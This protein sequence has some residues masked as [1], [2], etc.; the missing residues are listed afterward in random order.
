MK[1]RRV[2]LIAC[3]KQKRTGIHKAMDLYTSPLFRYALQYSARFDRRFI[4]SGGYGLVYP[5]AS[6][7]AY[8][9]ALRTMSYDD[10]QAWA[11]STALRIR[12]HVPKGAKIYWLCGKT[13]REFLIH[14]LS[15]YLH[16]APLAGLKIGQQLQWY[17]K[18]CKLPRLN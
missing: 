6:I 13:Y 5:G 10:R 14:R 12:R 7:E 11:R 8:N 3:S 9:F 18:R 4:L 15:D 1:V 17:K 2:A 16:V